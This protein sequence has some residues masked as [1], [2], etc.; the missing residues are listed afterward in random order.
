LHPF[1]VDGIK[2]PTNVGIKHPVCSDN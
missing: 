1:M 2:E